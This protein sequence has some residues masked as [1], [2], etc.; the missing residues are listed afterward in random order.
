MSADKD[1]S[2]QTT[3]SGVSGELRDAQSHLLANKNLDLYEEKAASGLFSLG[4]K[5]L[6]VKT[7][8]NGQFSFEYPA[9]TYALVSADDF[10]RSNI[11]WNITIGATNSYRTLTTSLI[12]FNLS[13]P[14]GQGLASNPSLQLYS[15]TG[16]NGVYYRDALVGTVKLVSNSASLS[17]AAGPYLAFYAGLGNQSFGQAFYAKN[18]SA[19]TV[20]IALT[21]KYLVTTTKA[22]Y[23]SGVPTNAVP[24]VS[25]PASADSPSSSADSSLVARLKGRILLQVEAQGQAWYV[26]PLDSLK[27]S[28]GRP[29]DAFNMMRRFALGVSNTNFASIAAS[30][31]SWRNLAGRILLKTQDSGKAYYFDP[32][33]L[34]LYYLGRPQDAFNI[35]R[36]RG[37]GITNSNL[38]K[39]TTGQ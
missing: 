17:L 37:L 3:F 18:G 8:S 5:L 31:S 16:S 1:Y 9:G 30:P 32:T 33:N 2:F 11:F 23:L 26:N 13:D 34:Q 24:V 25:Q 35:M 29:Q 39:I 12:T 10:N 38:A 6:S 28:L 22:F 19:Y 20:N 4:K 15:L 7:D 14:Q 21:S 36:N 27:Y